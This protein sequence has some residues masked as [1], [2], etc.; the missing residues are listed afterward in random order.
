M[1]SIS[2]CIPAFNRA[3]F[4][5]ELLDSVYLEHECFSE[6]LICEDCSPERSQISSIVENFKIAHPGLNI[7]YIEN[8]KNLGYDGNIRR[9]IELA[10]SDYCLFLGNDDL[11]CRGSLSVIKNTLN[12]YSNCG[13][14]IRSYA[15]FD[16][17]PRKIKQEF[18]YFPNEKLLGPG[19]SAISTAFR[20]SVVIPGLVIHRESAL[21]VATSDY[22]GTLLYQLY[23]VGMILANRC[24]V[25]TPKIIA[26]R[27]DGNLPDF[28]NSEVEKGKFVP[29]EQTV[30]SSLY[31]VKGMLEIA[32]GLEVRTGFKVF[33]R[34]RADISRYSY[35]I[36]GIQAHRSRLVF[37]G[38][39]FSLSRLGLGCSPLFY[40]YFFGLLILGPQFMDKVVFYLKSKI[41][42]APRL[43]KIE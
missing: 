20:R 14:L 1:P 7:R 25:F 24:V 31:F 41:G 27:R 22:D 9:L 37:T 17:D 8:Q 36:L 21:R 5:K 2:I 30:E 35:P 33:A 16:K 18:R 26:L 3:N 4:L 11:L 32:R 28:G 42:Y 12:S 43:G 29:H 40:G 19:V 39:A 10:C 34:I 23:L 15:T 13:V 6:V 38:Y